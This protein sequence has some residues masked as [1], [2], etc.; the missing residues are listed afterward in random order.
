MDTEVRRSK[1]AHPKKRRFS[2]ESIMAVVILVHSRP[3]AHGCCLQAHISQHCPRSTQRQW[4]PNRPYWWQPGA[5]HG[6]VV[7]SPST[8][9]THAIR[10]PGGST[11]ESLEGRRKEGMGT[12]LPAH[13]G[14]TPLSLH[15]CSQTPLSCNPRE[16]AFPLASSCVFCLWCRMLSQGT[17][18]Q[19]PP[20]PFSTCP[21]WR[22]SP[23]EAEGLQHKVPCY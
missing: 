6:E 1:T 23:G 19:P 16:E 22:S 15:S 4:A 13:M 17:P 3:P 2:R 20:S 12:G 10:S 14:K 9:P 5:A 11:Q 21:C 7:K 8:E 18:A